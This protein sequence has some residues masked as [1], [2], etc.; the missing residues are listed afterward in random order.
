MGDARSSL[1]LYTQDARFPHP[2]VS[3][4]LPLPTP[5]L[6][7]FGPNAGFLGSDVLVLPWELLGR[8]AL[9]ASRLEVE[10][11]SL[12]KSFYA[13]KIQETCGR[14]STD[15]DLRRSDKVQ[16]RYYDASRAPFRCLAFD[17]CRW[18]LLPP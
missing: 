14:D 5:M 4:P 3:R 16:V 15:E 13:K 10:E 1:T 11:E 8:W 7:F 6:L 2:V 9:L 18:L 17:S 12:V